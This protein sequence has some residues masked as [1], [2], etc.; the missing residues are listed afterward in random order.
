MEEG[1]RFLIAGHKVRVFNGDVSDLP[2]DV[3]AVVSSDDNY[4]SHGGGV[5][6]ALWNVAG[7]ELAAF[8]NKRRPQLR[9]GDVFLTPAFNANAIVMF[10]VITIDLDQNRTVTEA[11]LPTLYLALFDK[12]S[13]AACRRVALPLLGAGGAGM[14]P[15][16]SA[17]AFVDTLTAAPSPRD[18][19]YDFTLALH[20]SSDRKAIA[21]LHDAAAREED[22]TRALERVAEILPPNIA[23]EL[24]E[25]WGEY[26]G[27]DPDVR[28]RSLALLWEHVSDVLKL[29]PGALD[30]EMARIVSREAALARNRLAHGR[31]PSRAHDSGTLLAAVRSTL[32][33]VAATSPGENRS[34]HLESADQPHLWQS[35]QRSRQSAARAPQPSLNLT[36]VSPAPG[37][38]ALTPDS[39]TVQSRADRESSSPPAAAPLRELRDFLTKYLPGDSLGD[40]DERLL[41]EGYKGP[42]EIRLLEFLIRE[43]ELDEFLASEFGNAGLRGAIRKFRGEE[44]DKKL[45]TASKLAEWF[46][47]TLGFPKPVR[48]A[49]LRAAQQAVDSARRQLLLNNDDATR[50]AIGEVARRL[51]Y[52]CR[53]ILRFVCQAAYRR[54]PELIL[55]EWEHIGEGETLARSSLG[56]LIIFVESLNSHLQKDEGSEVELFRRDVAKSPLLPEDAGDLASL[57]N[58]FSHYRKP[59]SEESL[60]D[61]KVFLSGAARFLDHLARPETRMF[62]RIV[63]VE[64]IHFDKWGRKVI[65][66]VDDEGNKEVIF[67][68]DPVAPGQTYFMHPLTNPLRVDPILV[69]AGDL[70]WLDA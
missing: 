29:F 21:V 36:F 51:E 60:H 67:T 40:L 9:L 50:G 55:R 61:A 45:R 46:L 68:D 56:S 13:E 18:A 30:E 62:P 12:I 69:P 64:N 63:L 28:A 54:A 3:D 65:E 49:G 70:L 35:D 47:S 44:P 26:L 19:S 66:A 42:P 4:L 20:R 14:S 15:L 17:T 7:P 58:A 24:R 48:P 34:I 52:I 1:Q 41:Q 43:R 38:T 32:N 6:R 37:A 2:Y 22:I 16:A 11:D 57:R 59:E 39:P 5:S 31:S 53:V 27:S 23:M 33:A 25:N 8:V 10:H